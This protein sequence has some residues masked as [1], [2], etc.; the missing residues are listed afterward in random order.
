MATSSYRPFVWLL[1]KTRSNHF[2]LHK[3]TITDKLPSLKHRFG[4][5]I[6]ISNLE[7]FVSWFC[8]IEDFHGFSLAVRR[9][10]RN[11]FFSPLASPIWTQVFAMFKVWTTRHMR[12]SR[13][14]LTAT[15]LR[16]SKD[17]GFGLDHIHLIIFIDWR[18]IF[19]KLGAFTKSSLIPF[20]DLF[21]RKHF[22]CLSWN[23][24]VFIFIDGFLKSPWRDAFFDWFWS[25]RYFSSGRQT[26]SLDWDWKLL[27]SLLYILAQLRLFLSFK[28]VG[29]ALLDI[30]LYQLDLV[31]YILMFS[32]F[33]FPFALWI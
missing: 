10:K 31:F 11:Q 8:V 13:N 21:F 26:C 33:L 23:F 15:N 20:F 29:L 28:F 16:S 17:F 25:F 30:T 5:T 27:S 1:C 7:Y 4:I 12:E 22:K 19:N 2:V 3:M 18:I 24:T 9:W 32:D 14:F 6:S